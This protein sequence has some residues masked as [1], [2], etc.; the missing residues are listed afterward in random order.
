MQ[1][2][3]EFHAGGEEA[4]ALLA[5]ALAVELFPPLG[6]KPE[7]GII[8]GQKL[9]GAAG[10]VQLIPDGGI[11]P[12]GAVVGGVLTGGHHLRRARH[13][14]LNVHT[15]HG[16]GQQAHG[17]EDGVA[18]ADVVR[19]HKRLPALRVGQGLQS[20]FLPVCGGINPHP[21]ALF[22]VLF[23]QGSPEEP[24][25]HGG[26]RGGTGFGDDIHGEIHILHQV[27]NFLQSIC[28]QA[29]ARKIDVGAVLFLQ[30][31]IGGAEAVDDTLGP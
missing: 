17:C 23:L 15:G 27:Q 12:G 22:A 20:A 6:H 16:D 7:R 30:V 21:C 9:N 26:L 8:A 1:V 24:E 5:L 2:R 14:L 10:A 29:V 13:Q 18:A 11:L 31:V 25:G 3:R 28:G 4:L 19:H